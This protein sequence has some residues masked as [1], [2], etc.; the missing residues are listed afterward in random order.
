MQLLKLFDGHLLAVLYHKLIDI[1]LIH[2]QSLRQRLCLAVDYRHHRNCLKPLK[3]TFDNAFR[4]KLIPS[5]SEVSLGNPFSRSFDHLEAGN[6][7]NL[8]QQNWYLQSPE[9]NTRRVL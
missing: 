3:V 9:D 2:L 5:R 7:Q 8:R 6:V 1:I 4:P